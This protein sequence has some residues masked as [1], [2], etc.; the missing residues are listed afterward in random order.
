MSNDVNRFSEKPVTQIITAT[1]GVKLTF[2]NVIPST[3][4]QGV[5]THFETTEGRFIL[6]NNTNVFAIEV[7]KQI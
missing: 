2:K 7:I 5:M 6:I 1:T 4:A 3:I